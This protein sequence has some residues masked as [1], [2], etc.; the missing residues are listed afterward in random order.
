M[1]SLIQSIR[2]IFFKSKCI[3]C[4]DKT[5]DKLKYICYNC[6]QKL[7]ESSSLKKQGAVYYIW[8]YDG[9]FKKLISEYK[10]KNKLGIA[11]ILA[12]LIKVQLSTV[13]Q[14]EE[15]EVVI[16]VPIS[17]QRMVERGFNQVEE[18]VK[19]LGYPYFQVKRIKNTEHMYKFLS[20][21][22]REKNID[23]SFEITD[24][25]AEDKTVLILDDIIT[26]GSTVRELIK[27]IRKSGEPRKIVIFSLA[28][29]KTALETEL[30][31]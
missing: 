3:L 14:S 19:C 28:I 8:N 2:K 6:H 20:K 30:K 31:F 27:E 9:T 13:M 4:D 15:V 29:A 16:P 11:Q 25:D 23:R 1:K 26:T 17:K 22:E 7:I 24:L 5:N 10:M 18:I 21:E 12:D